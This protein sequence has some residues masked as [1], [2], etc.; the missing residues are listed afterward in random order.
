MAA[1]SPRG[2]VALRLP[3]RPRAAHK[4]DFGRVLIV[5]GS[6]SMPGAAALCALAALRSG[7][8]LV[9]LAAGAKVLDRIAGRVLGATFLELPAMP[10]GTLAEAA[11]ERVLARAGEFDAAALGPGLGRGSGPAAVVARLFPELPCPTIVDADALN[12]LADAPR[13]FELPRPARRVLTPHPGEM[14]RLLGAGAALG[15]EPAVRERACAALAS[16]TK[17]CVVLKGAGT[18][19]REGERTFTASTGNPGLA[20]GG[21]GD[22]LTGMLAALAARKELEP[23]D[24]VCLGVH[25]HG[26]AGDLAAAELGED[27]MMTED[28]LFFLPHA[29]RSL[30]ESAP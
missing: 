2:R 30:A 11:A 13:T 25:A 10:D 4:G 7:A 16:R 18:V 26:L 8:G 29:W 21:T 17:T 24:A 27:G 28:L 15:A 19:I 5:A 6:S 12:E 3:E 23:F 14:A 20:K 22:V 1:R 9:T